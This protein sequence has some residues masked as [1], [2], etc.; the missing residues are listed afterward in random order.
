MSL[1]S[2]TMMKLM[3]YADG[4]LEGA[5]R[6]E[7]EKL[8]LKEPDAARFIADVANLGTYAEEIH[9]SRDAKAVAK[10]DL[11]NAIMAKVEKPAAAKV[12]P[13]SGARKK[14]VSGPVIG[15]IV[16]AMAL[17]ASIFL[18][19]KPEETPMAKAPPPAP[20]P[21]PDT[22]PGIEV[23]TAD[24]PGQKVQVFYGPGKTEMQTSVVIWVD[25]NVG[26]KK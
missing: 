26:E 11:T 12:V 15:G 18:F 5:D 2:E 1:D 13:I 10:I 14:K 22:V 21:Q 4:E 25:D 24:S 23:D 17:A 20:A 7:V 16:A 6:A 9:A 3:A 19:A 8:L